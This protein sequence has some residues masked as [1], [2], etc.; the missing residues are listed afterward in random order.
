MTLIITGCTSDIEVTPTETITTANTKVIFDIV[1]TEQYQ[2]RSASVGDNWPNALTKTNAEAT[3]KSA[4]TDLKNEGLSFFVN[5]YSV[6][7]NN[8][9]TNSSITSWNG[10]ATLSLTEKNTITVTLNPNTVGQFPKFKLANGWIDLSNL[11]LDNA[12][13]TFTSDNYGGDIEIGGISNTNGVINVTIKVNLTY[14]S[15]LLVAPD[16]DWSILTNIKG[17]STLK[18]G[19]SNGT[20][21]FTQSIS[22]G[23]WWYYW[24]EGN[25]YVWGKGTLINY[26]F[27]LYSDGTKDLKVETGKWYALFASLNSAGEGDDDPNNPSDQDKTHT[28]GGDNGITPT[29]NDIVSGGA[30]R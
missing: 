18:W 30:I 24:G 19:G 20:R 12:T 27:N 14:D 16:A 1:S 9:T 11:D 17:F 8:A 25:D 15:Y 28:V 2:T 26:G 10:S 5:N 3:V 21:F 6:A 7:L 4:Y 29:T 23:K 22:G 13:P